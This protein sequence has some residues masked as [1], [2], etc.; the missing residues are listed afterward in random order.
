MVYDGRYQEKVKAITSLRNKFKTLPIILIAERS[1]IEEIDKEL[2]GQITMFYFLDQDTATFAAGRIHRKVKD[3]IEQ[4]YPPFFKALRNY[5]H[6]YK[7]AWHTPG[8][9][10]GEGFLKSPAGIAFYNFYGENVMRSDLSVSVPE[11]GSLLDHSGVVKDSE[12]LAEETF[13]SDLTYYILM[14][15]LLLTRPFGIHR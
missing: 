13:N 6:D 14:V 12:K 1:L 11:L 9:M 7:Y 2:I 5:V 3:Y 10:G 15:P 4:Q 8:H